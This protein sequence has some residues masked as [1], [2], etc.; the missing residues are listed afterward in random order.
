M[1]EAWG[2][3][4]AMRLGCDLGLTHVQLEGNALNVV[5]ALK[6]EGP[7]WS[8]FGHLIADTCMC[9][10]QMLSYSNLSCAPSSQFGGPYVS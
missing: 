10:A 9:L 4:S 3:W 7:C 6:K 2:A 5:A 1:A 8:P